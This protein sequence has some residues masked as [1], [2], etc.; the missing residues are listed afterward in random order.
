MFSQSRLAQAGELL[1]M[2]SHQWRQPIS[3]IASIASNLRFKIMLEI[4]WITYI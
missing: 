1:S 2:I 3:K 4:R